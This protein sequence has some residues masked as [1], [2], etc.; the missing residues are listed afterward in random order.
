[1]AL[2]WA[3]L[4]T[5]MEKSG[6]GGSAHSLKNFVA[7][8][9]A[10]M[11]AKTSTA[12]LD[13]LKILLQAQKQHYRGHG[14]P[15]G[16]AAIVRNEGVLALYKGNGAMMVRIFPYA[17]I[18]FTS[19]ERYN[20]MMESLIGKRSIGRL[21]AGSLAGVTAVTFTYPLDVAR[22]RFAF[23]VDEGKYRSILQTLQ[24]IRRT[25]GGLRGVYRG[26]VPT[27]LGIIPYGG[28]AFFSYGTL[29]GFLLERFPQ[30]TTKITSDGS[31]AP[32]VPTT[33]A[34]GA[35]AGALAQTVSY[36]L[37]VSR[38]RMQL[39]GMTSSIAENKTIFRSL[40]HTYRTNGIYRGLFRGL[41]INYWRA[42]PQ[43]AVSFS[44]YELM[45]QILNRHF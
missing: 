35:I 14:V 34:C 33:L 37:D 22:A 38:R 4:L 2:Y 28:V 1:M 19:F 21:V 25:E 23:Q 30:Y 42:S 41:S 29:K 45:K 32:S 5:A 7:G 27:V 40:V 24:T 12:P 20:R 16:L 9:V 3:W 17:A 8:G 10:G 18:Q 11:C 31:P 6:S 36:P 39:A 43:V 15:S 26:F 44:V 13:R